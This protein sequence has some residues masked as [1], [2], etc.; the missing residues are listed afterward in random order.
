MQLCFNIERAGTSQAAHTLCSRKK[1]QTRWTG[2]QD[3]ADKHSK[4]HEALDKTGQ[5]NGLKDKEKE[6]TDVNGKNEMKLVMP[7]LLKGARPLDFV[8]RC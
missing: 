1:N 8:N 2:H 4:I 6:L 3:M 7:N 5:C